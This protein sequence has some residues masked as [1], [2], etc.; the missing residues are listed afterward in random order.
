[1]FKDT[2]LLKSVIIGRILRSRSKKTDKNRIRLMSKNILTSHVIYKKS[3]LFVS[4]YISMNK[5]IFVL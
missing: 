3:F 2:T 5:H 4:T 1:M